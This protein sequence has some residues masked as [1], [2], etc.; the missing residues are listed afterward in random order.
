M[1]LLDNYDKKKEAHEDLKKI[2]TPLD[3]QAVFQALIFLALLGLLIIAG[4]WYGYYTTHSSTITSVASRTNLVISVQENDTYGGCVA[5]TTPGDIQVFFGM[6][7]LESDPSIVVG[8]TNGLCTTTMSDGGNYTQYCLQ[9]YLFLF[10]VSG[11]AIPG[12]TIQTAGNYTVPEDATSYPK[13][14][15]AITGGTGAY[16]H[17]QGQAFIITAASESL[18]MTTLNVDI[19]N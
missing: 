11:S 5:C 18:Y 13:A 4:L 7:V 6:L 16:I 8:S 19:L 14:T 15:W 3:A 9:Q 17:A 10:P 12:G 1:S 2:K